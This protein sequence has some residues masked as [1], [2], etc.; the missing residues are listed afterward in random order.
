MSIIEEANNILEE[1]R[2]EEFVKNNPFTSEIEE[3][4]FIETEKIFLLSLPEFEK[5]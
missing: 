2:G 3:K 5:Y 4:M 1:I